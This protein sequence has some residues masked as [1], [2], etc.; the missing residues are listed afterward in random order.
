MDRLVLG[1]SAKFY[2]MAHKE[3]KGEIKQI[4]R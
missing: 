2:P 4:D 1:I 3:A